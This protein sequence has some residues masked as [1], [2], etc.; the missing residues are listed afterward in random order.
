V[1]YKTVAEQLFGQEE[2][3]GKKIYIGKV[4]FEVSGVKVPE[5]QASIFGGSEMNSMVIIPITMAQEISQ[6]KVIHRIGIEVKDTERVEEVKSKVKQAILGIHQGEED[7]S[8]MTQKELLNI[9]DQIINLLTTALTG[10]AAISLIVGG[11]GI[12]NIMLVSVTERTKEIGLRK[13][14]GA[15]NANILFQFM[16]EALII[17]L[18]GGLVGVG[19]AFLGSLVLSAKLD[20]PAVININSVLLALLFAGGV[21]IIFGVAP[22]IRASRLNPIDALRYE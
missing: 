20:L 13:A 15:S 19:L 14:I 3:L 9:F 5:E 6:S 21:G 11:I 17:S 16:I 10:I 1:I 8:V 7:F 4:E 12:M 18:L 2:A 22:A